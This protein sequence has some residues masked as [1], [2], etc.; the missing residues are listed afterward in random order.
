M[1][2]EFTALK[3]NR[4]WH[5]VP[6]PPRANVVSGKWIFRHKLK[7]DG[8]LDRYKTLWVLRGFTQR[9]GVDYRET[10]SPVVKPP[11]VQ[12]VLSIAISQNW[13][14][15]QLDINNAFLHGTLTEIVYCA[16][17]SGF[18]DISQPDH[19]CRLNKSLYGLKQAPRAW[20]S[21]F[22]DHLLRLGFIGSRTD[23][24]LFIYTRTTET[25][26]LLLYVDD[27]VLTASYEQLLRQTITALEREF[28]LKDLG[29][30]HYFLGV[31]VTRSSDGMFL[32]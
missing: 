23:P 17:P 2:D 18:I 32:S 6:C 16:Q 27:I 7:P 22:A 24:S 12:T 26:Y 30:L 28:S 29:A 1:V 21:R 10:F 19:V 3:N 31:V 9:A 15:H 14:V 20:Y 8:S 25:V 4:T 5:L 11:T 13:P